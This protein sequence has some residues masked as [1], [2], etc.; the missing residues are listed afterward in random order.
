MDGKITVLQ[1]YLDWESNYFRKC[2]L[3]FVMVDMKHASN[4]I[5]WYNPISK[6]FYGVPFVI[7]CNTCLFS[8]YFSL[9][10]SSFHVHHHAQ[11]NKI[12]TITNKIILTN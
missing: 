9:F 7:K 3:S 2:Q 5:F 8:N 11:H 10:N 6:L 4:L 1:K 12:S